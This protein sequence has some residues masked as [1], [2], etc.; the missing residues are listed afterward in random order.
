MAICFSGKN[1]RL[2]QRLIYCAPLLIIIKLGGLFMNIISALL[3]IFFAGIANGS[4]ALPTKY[5][6]NWKFE[7]IWLHFSF[8]AFVLLPWIIG[9]ALVPQIFSIYSQASPQILL[10]MLIGGFIFGLGQMCFALALNMIGLGLGFIINLGLGIVLGFLLPLLFKNPDKIFTTFGLFTILGVLLALAGLLFSNRAGNIHNK[11]KQQM[12]GMQAAS[13]K[14]YTVGV[15]LAI[16]AGLS[17]AG[18]NFAFAMTADMQQIALQAGA[19]AFGAANIMWPGF[20]L[21]GFIPYAGY[22][23]FLHF[24]NKSFSSYSAPES[25]KYMLFAMIMGLFWYG[26]LVFYSKATMLIGSLGPVVGWPMFMVL[27]ILV[28]NFWGWRHREWEGASTKVK[29]TLWT[30]LLCLVAAVAVLGYSSTL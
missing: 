2:A 5:V 27:I 17:S 11:E 3:L 6:T 23:L 4:F 15:I 7:N 29:K 8:W 1:C 13:S 12:A 19:G 21:C 20:L 28:S 26:S 16:L 24:K 10:I 14:L 9:F 18:Q 25:K 22:N 30:G